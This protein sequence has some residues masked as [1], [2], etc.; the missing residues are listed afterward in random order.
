MLTLS[1]REKERERERERARLPAA[2]TTNYTSYHRPG[3]TT[4][5]RANVLLIVV[6]VE[7]R[8]CFL[9]FFSFL[10]LFFRLSRSCSA[11]AKLSKGL[12][13]SR[14]FS[15]LALLSSVMGQ[16]ACTVWMVL[17]VGE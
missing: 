13:H 17:V 2:F 3:L 12:P 1:Q 6:Q 7:S 5:V 4:R 16:G 11:D 10:F 15:K 14:D 8:V 9:L